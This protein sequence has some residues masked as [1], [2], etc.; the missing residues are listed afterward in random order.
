MDRVWLRKGSDKA[1][2]ISPDKVER[3]SN[4]RLRQ[5]AAIRGVAIFTPSL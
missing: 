1:S 5:V 3:L 4:G 2:K